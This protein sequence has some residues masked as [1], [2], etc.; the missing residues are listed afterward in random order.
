MSSSRVNFDHFV[1]DTFYHVLASTSGIGGSFK[2]AIKSVI[3]G[4]G[5]TT[6]PDSSFVVL[7]RIDGV[8][9]EACDENELQ[10]ACHLYNKLV[11]QKNA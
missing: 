10:D 4:Q 3:H 7:K 5:H 6:K 9:V 11:G 8:D 1:G 2:L